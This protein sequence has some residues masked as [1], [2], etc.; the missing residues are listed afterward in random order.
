MLNQCGYQAGTHPETIEGV[1][2]P[3]SYS[4]PTAGQQNGRSTAAGQQRS[5]PAAA[6]QQRRR[7]TATAATRQ[8]RS[9]ALQRSDS[10]LQA[11]PETE[12]MSASN[13]TLAITCKVETH[14]ARRLT[15]AP[16]A[17]Q[18]LFVLLV[19]ETASSGNIRRQT[20]SRP[21]SHCLLVTPPR[22]TIGTQMSEN[23]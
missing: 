5:R 23:K 20:I 21:L 11:R 1:Y 9:M 3:K 12:V 14:S 6:R 19:R 22:I 7:P 2:R 15:T 13:L 16:E 4:Y 18:V 17:P 10:N 8:R